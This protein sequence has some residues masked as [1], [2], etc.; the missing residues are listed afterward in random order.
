MGR[1]GGAVPNS[2]GGPGAHSDAWGRGVHGPAV[3]ACMVHACCGHVCC[4]CACVCA[5]VV[6]CAC[7]CVAARPRGRHRIHAYYS[8]LQALLPP[9]CSGSDTGATYIL[10]CLWPATTGLVP[11]TTAA[12]KARRRIKG[13]MAAGAHLVR[14]KSVT[15]MPSASYNRL[16][17]AHDRCG[18]GAPAHAWQMHG[19]GGG[20]MAAER[21]ADGGGC[22]R[23]RLRTADGDDW[24]RRTA[25]ADGGLRRPRTMHHGR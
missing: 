12:E 4:V 11:H 22:G 25:A 8:E 13:C 3:R 21:T 18:E 1:A 7:V 5:C 20:C 10:A 23:R 16:G 6:C 24:R 17:A 19:A 2:P 15:G 9:F 14:Y